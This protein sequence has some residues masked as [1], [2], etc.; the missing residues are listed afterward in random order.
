MTIQDAFQFYRENNSKFSYRPDFHVYNKLLLEIQNTNNIT[1]ECFNEDILSYLTHNEDRWFVFH[2]LTVIDELPEELFIPIMNSI[3]S[4]GFDNCPTIL[5]DNIARLYGFEKVELYLQDEFALSYSDIY[6]RSIVEAMWRISYSIPYI[7]PDDDLDFITVRRYVWVKN[8]Y[9]FLEFIPDSQ[10]EGKI[11][12]EK[13]NI[14]I[15]N[16]YKL[17][18]EH[19]LKNEIFP[20][21][22]YDCSVVLPR[23]RTTYKNENVE[24]FKKLVENL[25]DI[26]NNSKSNFAIYLNN[27]V[28]N[29]HWI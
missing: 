17:L 6:K 11:M 9:Q 27:P 23:K 4:I 5:Y 19:F 2:L 12:L 8:G 7:I 24:L 20:D 25:R 10:E 14:L 21:F 26:K 1:S 29:W 22:F 18:L 16:R 28:N 3:L 13:E 15:Q